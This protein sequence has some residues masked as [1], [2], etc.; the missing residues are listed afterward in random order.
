MN[1]PTHSKL[2]DR[3]EKHIFPLGTDQTQKIELLQVA[4][5]HKLGGVIRDSSFGV[6][7]LD[8]IST[9]PKVFLGANGP[10]N[11]TSSVSLPDPTKVVTYLYIAA[12]LA[13]LAVLLT[14]VK[15]FF[16]RILGPLLKYTNYIIAAYVV[17][18]VILFGMASKDFMQMSQ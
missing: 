14:A 8:H 7:G 9:C 15:I 1:L 3:H 10:T 12:I 4:D 16:P 11:G 13:G 17:I 6:Q 2:T 5:V 18:A